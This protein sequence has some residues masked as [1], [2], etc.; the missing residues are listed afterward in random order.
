[1]ETRVVAPLMA[2]LAMALG[3]GC[4]DNYQGSRIEANLTVVDSLIFSRNDLILPTP[5]VPRD[6]P[7]WFS[8]YELHANILGAGTIRLANFT[9]QPCLHLLNPCS[10]F[11]KDIYCRAATGSTC[12][13]YINL[14]RFRNIAEAILMVVSVPPTTQDGTDYIHAPGYDFMDR[15]LWPDELF[16]DPS[17]TDPNAKLHRD[18]LNQPAVAAFCKRLPEDYYLGN[19]NQLS[20]PRSGTTAGPVDGS[21]PRTNFFVGGLTLFTPANLEYMSELMLIRE[22]DAS[23]LSPERLHENLA[24]SDTSQVLLLGQKHGSFG[25]IRFDRYRGVMSVFMTS[26]LGLPITWS[27]VIY[28]DLNKDPLNF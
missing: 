1:M 20:L 7:R 4:V 24:P 19:P 2:I 9:I 17:L 13:P 21:D 8:H 26:P 28:Y 22:R 6:D 14:E 18:N 11:E 10:Q 25:S 12:S 16:V 23:R 5:G 3:S 27:S 15:E